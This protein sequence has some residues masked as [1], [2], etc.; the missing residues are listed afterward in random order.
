MYCPHRMLNKAWPALLLLGACLT[1]NAQ[2]V[3]EEIVVTAQKREQNL[4]EV[5][6]AITAFTGE[7][8]A[9]L[10]FQE[11]HDIFSQAPNVHVQ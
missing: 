8:I 3:L 2:G 10:G 11:P 5:P 6:V 1:G 9:Q 4:Q 7:A